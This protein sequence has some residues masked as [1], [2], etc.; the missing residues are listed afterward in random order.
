MQDVELIG[1][2]RSATKFIK[3][4]FKDENNVNRLKKL[5]VTTMDTRRLW[6]GSI[7]VS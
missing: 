2:Q 3:K 4:S 5:H 1:V 6:G 7:E